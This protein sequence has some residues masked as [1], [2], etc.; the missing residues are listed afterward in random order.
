MTAPAEPRVGP[1]VDALRAL[2][3]RVASQAGPG[4]QVEAYVSQGTNSSVD[5]YE[6]QI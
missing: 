6:G 3:D 5:A 1:D 4:E 2:A